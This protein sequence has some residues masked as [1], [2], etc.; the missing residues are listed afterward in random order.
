LLTDKEK[1]QIWD[2]DHAGEEYC[3]SKSFCQVV[4]LLSEFSEVI[5]G[6]YII[7][8]LEGMIDAWRVWNRIP[9][10]VVIIDGKRYVLVAIRS[11]KEDDLARHFYSQ[12][13]RDPKGLFS[14]H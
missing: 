10:Q 8:D 9:V 11:H 5:A 14:E 7:D 13:W 1:Q 12:I 6:E 3:E 2:S 4:R